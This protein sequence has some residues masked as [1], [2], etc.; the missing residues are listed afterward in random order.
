MMSQMEPELYMTEV[1]PASVTVDMM[2]AWQRA[3]ATYHHLTSRNCTNLEQHIDN[4]DWEWKF[5]RKSKCSVYLGILFSHHRPAV[6]TQCKP[7]KMTKD[8]LFE[9][10]NTVC[11][12]TRLDVICQDQDVTRRQRRL[13]QRGFLYIFSFKLYCIYSM[14]ESFVNKITD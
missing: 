3:E 10:C 1:Y 14:Q 8:H 7:G 13:V 11:D 2:K 6:F 12:G 5:F 9:C 4:K